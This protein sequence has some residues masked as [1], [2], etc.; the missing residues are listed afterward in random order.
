M[1]SEIGRLVSRAGQR[2]ASAEQRLA[3]AESITGGHVQALLTSVAGA[4]D[5]FQGGITAYSL[6]QKVAQLGVDRAMAARCHCVSA[7]VARQMA[8]GVC[9]RFQT[10]WGLATT[11]FAEPN[12][13][14]ETPRAFVAMARCVSAG[15]DPRIVLSQECTLAGSRVENQQRVARFAVELLLQQLA[16]SPSAAPRNS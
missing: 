15:R 13:G 6:E 16:P 1:D 14:G 5:F 11:G 7:D 4:S 12:P 2:L 3:V 10:H 9:R 8:L